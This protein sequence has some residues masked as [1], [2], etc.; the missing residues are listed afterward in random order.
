MEKAHKNRGID[1]K[2]PLSE[3]SPEVG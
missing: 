1:E 2:I 3:K